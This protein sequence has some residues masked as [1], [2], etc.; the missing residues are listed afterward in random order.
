MQRSLLL[1]KRRDG[2]GRGPRS[3]REH[4]RRARWRVSRPGHGHEPG[5]TAAGLHGGHRSSLRK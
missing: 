2:E 1:Y 5:R 4:G 3:G